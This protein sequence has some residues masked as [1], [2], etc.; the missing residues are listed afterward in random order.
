MCFLTVS[1]RIAENTPL[2]LSEYVS[3]RELWY[4]K[5]KFL[6]TFQESLVAY[7]AHCTSYFA[8][9]SQ[10]PENATTWD[11][12][13]VFEKLMPKLTLEAS[14]YW[15]RGFRT[16]KWVLELN[17]GI[18]KKETHGNCS[19]HSSAIKDLLILLQESTLEG[20]Q[21][22]AFDYNAIYSILEQRQTKT[23]TKDNPP[24][25]PGRESEY[26]NRFEKRFATYGR[27]FGAI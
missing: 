8:L 18:L 14:S 2:L 6:Q 15:R 1:L 12:L 20:I 21:S 26:D 23:R 11:P 3:L 9:L 16:R 22:P 25:K 4:W 17:Y 24:P 7:P 19:T 27:P 5:Q 10:F 13:E